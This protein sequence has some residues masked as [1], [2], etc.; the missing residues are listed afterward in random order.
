MNSKLNIIPERFKNRWTVFTQPAIYKW[1]FEQSLHQNFPN[2]T[3][4][5]KCKFLR[6]TNSPNPLS[7]P[8][9]W[10]SV[11]L[12]RA[13]RNYSRCRFS[14]VSILATFLWWLQTVRWQ[15]LLPCGQR[16]LR[17]LDEGFQGIQWLKGNSG[18]CIS[19]TCVR[20]FFGKIV[21]RRIRILNL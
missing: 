18:G 8:V 1:M 7:V 21:R 5:A 20:E 3:S 19:V 17:K 14:S 12:A 15:K 6:A 10:A 16:S 11:Q 13:N 9:Y 4:V 2:W